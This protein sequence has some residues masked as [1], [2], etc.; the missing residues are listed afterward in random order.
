LSGVVAALA[1]AACVGIGT[2]PPPPPETPEAELALRAQA[3]QRTVQEAAVAGA[4]AG[5]GGVYVFGGKGPAPAL[6]LIGGIPMGIATGTY[7]GY[8]QQQYATREARLERLRSDI[9]LTNAETAAAIR[10][11]RVVLAE[12]QRQLAALRAGTGG[13]ALSAQVSRAETDLA[14]MN[15]AVN[16][17][18][19]RLGEF[20]STRSLQLVEGEITGVDAQIG[21]LSQRIAEM[22]QIAGTLAGEI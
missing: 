5:A 12:Q 8:L 2:E 22:R 6:G 16:G 11:M 7:V 20:G 13:A 1:L 14:N 17:A 10:T 3:L 9:E 19:K 15:L 21:E 4:V 18:E